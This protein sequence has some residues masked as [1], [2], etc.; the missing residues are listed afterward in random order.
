MKKWIPLGVIAI[1]LTGCS[2]N[3]LSEADYFDLVQDTDGLTGLSDQQI[4][5]NGENICA[6]FDT[7]Q[8]A[9]MDALG[10]FVSEGIDAGTSGALIALSVRQYCPE[11]LDGI[12]G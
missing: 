2:N 10:V 7:S 11:H 4:K 6:V 12:P 3:T 1:A 5:T 8:N 9:Y